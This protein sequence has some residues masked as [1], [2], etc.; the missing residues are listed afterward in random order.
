MIQFTS[1]TLTLRGMFVLVCYIYE[2]NISHLNCRKINYIN[3]ILL[4]KQKDALLY[5]HYITAYKVNS[6]FYPPAAI[7][8]ATE[9][10]MSP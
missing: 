5:L 3:V 2:T 9:R 8:S 6:S 7:K 10:W 4:K 1:E